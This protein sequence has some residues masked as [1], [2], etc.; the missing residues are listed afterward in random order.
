M[1]LWIRS[2]DKR[3]LIECNDVAILK[4]TDGFKIGTCSI[5]SVKREV[6][7]GTYSTREKALKVLDFIEKKIVE[8]NNAIV[9][10]EK[11]WVKFVGAINCAFQM[12]LDKEVEE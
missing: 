6:D 9:C 2:Q 10:N 11:D 7:L 3:F 8:N 4:T 5:K 1:G 12:P